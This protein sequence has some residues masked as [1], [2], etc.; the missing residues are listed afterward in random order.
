V[1]LEFYRRFL[2]ER[3]EELR[4]AFIS[5]LEVLP[6]HDAQQK[7]AAV[8]RTLQL[9]EAFSRSISS[10]DHPAWLDELRQALSRYSNLSGQPREAHRLLRSLIKVSDPIRTHSWSVAPSE[11]IDLEHIFLRCVRESRLDELFDELIACT[12]AVINSERVDS[13]RIMSALESM[14]ATLRLNSAADFH[15]KSHALTFASALFKNFLWEAASDLPGLGTMMR[16]LRKTIDDVNEEMKRVEE[17]TKVEIERIAAIEKSKLI[18]SSR[19]KLLNAGEPPKDDP[20]T[21]PTS[22]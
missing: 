11:G 9:V 5:T 7:L 19:T 2:Y 12:E 8:N 21:E 22:I 16:S 18:G 3:L 20:D 4:A 13:V 15:Q 1:D 6:E 17:I 14:L 10:S